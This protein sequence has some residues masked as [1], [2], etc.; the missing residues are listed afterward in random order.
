MWLIFSLL[1]K[2]LKLAWLD[3]KIAE[4]KKRQKGD[5]KKTRRI[6]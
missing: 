6:N 1:S 2:Y 3:L 4:T 5:D